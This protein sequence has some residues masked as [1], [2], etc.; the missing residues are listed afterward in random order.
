M[1]ARGLLCKNLFPPGLVSCLRYQ[2]FLPQKA[3]S[4]EKHF[5]KPLCWNV[6]ENCDVDVAIN[7]AG[8]QSK[9]LQGKTTL[10]VVF[11][12]LLCESH[13]QVFMVLVFYHFSYV[14]NDNSEKKKERNSIR[15]ELRALLIS[16]P[17]SRMR[18]GRSFEVEILIC[19]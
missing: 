3:I 12:L 8:Y 2:L 15:V 17:P 7:H 10:Q 9:K 4:K 1:A 11:V 18:K 6:N 13:L 14:A 16:R 5:F 19:T